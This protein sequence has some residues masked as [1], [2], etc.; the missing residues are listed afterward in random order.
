M[1]NSTPL[2]RTDK[3]SPEKSVQRLPQSQ[4]KNW[5][6]VYLDSFKRYYW[7]YIFIL[8]ALAYYII[9]HYVPMGGLVIAFKRYTGAKSIWDSPWVGLRWFKSFF[10]SI[11]AKRTIVNTIILSF[12]D[13]A[14]FPLPILLAFVFDEVRN[15]TYKRVA[16]TVM[17]APHFVSTVVLVS[18]MSLFFNRDIGFINRIIEAFG[19]EP[20]AFMSDPKAF[21]HLYV[22]SGRWQST[23]WDC[24]IYVSALSAVDPSLHEAAKLDGASRFQQILHIKLP[25]IL[26]TIIIMLIMR[27]GHI[28][29]VGVDK[30]LLMRNDLNCT[31]AE[32]IGTYVYE[33]GLVQG[34]F[35]FSAAVGLFQNVI[36]F[37][38]LLAVNKI[39]AKVSETSLF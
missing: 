29:N 17:Y 20:R 39:S 15:K 7:L 31:T 18:M 28:M 30:V 8:P 34:S 13:L 26:P 12:Y 11:Y 1:R 37:S 22:W 24:I 23:G 36:N 10:D 14:L 35:S 25:T 32:T 9:F 6:Q 4:K 16:Q 27:V 19:G 5:S 2:K 3:G 33:R 21:R 38:M